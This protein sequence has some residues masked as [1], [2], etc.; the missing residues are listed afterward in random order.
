MY[1]Y[2]PIYTDPSSGT[3]MPGMHNESA[4]VVFPEMPYAPGTKVLHVDEESSIFVLS[5]DSGLPGWVFKTA[6]Q[7]NTD[8][9]GVL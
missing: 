7:I 9:P 3:T 1:F 2:A 6:E 5:S 8:Y 4:E